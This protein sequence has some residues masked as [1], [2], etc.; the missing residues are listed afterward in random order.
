MLQCCVRLSPTLCTECI[1]AKRCVLEQKL[2]LTVTAY[3][4][5]YMRNRLIPKWMTLTFVLFCFRKLSIVRLDL[6]MGHWWWHSGDQHRFQSFSCE[7]R[8]GVIPHVIRQGENTLNWHIGTRK[9][10]RKLNY[11]I[12]SILRHI[13]SAEILKF[14]SYFQPPIGL[15][16]LEGWGVNPCPQTLIFE[17][18]F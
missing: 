1:L 14:L 9:H 11:I 16:L 4:K 12:D 8:F 10:Q 13:Q 7:L 15:E 2:L 5:S 18:K 6:L 3:R 17:W